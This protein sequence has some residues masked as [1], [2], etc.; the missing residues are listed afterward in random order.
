M[1]EVSSSCLLS[2]VVVRDGLEGEHIVSE[3][4]G[5]RSFK[6]HVSMVNLIKRNK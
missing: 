3:R 4:G 5:M 1:R 6:A 2:G